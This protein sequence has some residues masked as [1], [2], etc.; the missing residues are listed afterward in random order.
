MASRSMILKFVENFT[1]IFY[2]IFLYVPKLVVEVKVEL[3]L[4]TEIAY[5]GYQKE[6]Y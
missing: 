5:N 1:F 2:F 4:H 3:L 6:K